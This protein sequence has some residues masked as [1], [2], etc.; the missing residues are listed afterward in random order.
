MANIG[1]QNTTEDRIFSA[2]YGLFSKSVYRPALTSHGAIY[3]F[4]KKTQLSLGFYLALV[5]PLFPKEKI[6]AVKSKMLISAH[7]GLGDCDI[8]PG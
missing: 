1:A 3:A 5:E 2:L 7:R 8:E 4:C 6:G